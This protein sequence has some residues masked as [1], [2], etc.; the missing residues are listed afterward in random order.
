VLQVV[1]AVGRDHEKRVEQVERFGPELH[2]QPRCELRGFGQ[3][4]VDHKLALHGQY[5]DW[6]PKSTS[7]YRTMV[8]VLVSFQPARRY[9]K[10]WIRPPI[11]LAAAEC[12]R[13]TTA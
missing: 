7:L 9:S 5:V 3:R 11:Y 4:R 8:T 6:K 2:A 13:V 1:V 12:V 10:W